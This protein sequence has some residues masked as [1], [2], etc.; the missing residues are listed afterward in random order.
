MLIAE[1]SDLQNDSS[2]LGLSWVK[3]VRRNNPLKGIIAR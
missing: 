3:Q 2:A 1:E